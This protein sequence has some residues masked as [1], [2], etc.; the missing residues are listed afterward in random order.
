MVTPTLSSISP[1]TVAAGGAGFTLTATG[2]NFVSG[3]VILWDGV[4]TADHRDLHDPAH[5]GR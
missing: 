1:T 3:T 2:T 5:A 4:A